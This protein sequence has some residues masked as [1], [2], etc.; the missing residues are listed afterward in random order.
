MEFIISQI[1]GIIALLLVCVGYFQKN[2]DNMMIFQSL[3]NVF[4]ASAFL[5]LKSYVGGI[6]VIISTIRC[7]Y[8]Y[9]SS[10][11]ENK[12]KTIYSKFILLFIPVYIIIGIVFWQSFF[13]F[14]PIITAS[15]FTIAFYVKDLQ[16]IRFLTLIPNAL[17]VFY[18][19][20]I[21]TYSNALLD[22]LEIIVCV[23][24]IIKFWKSEQQITNIQ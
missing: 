8:V 24:S 16:T 19:I 11:M 1:L 13:D 23:V 12:G 20:Y 15:M 3:A 17:L 2:K 22:M 7:L 6:I 5:V 21:T 4:Y 14:V 18:N 9:F 10:K